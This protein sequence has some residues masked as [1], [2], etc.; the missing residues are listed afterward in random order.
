MSKYFKLLSRNIER[1]T[2][3]RRGTPKG[4]IVQIKG[5]VNAYLAKPSS[6]ESKKAVL[7]LP[8]IFGIWQN[9]KLMADA[10]AAQG[11]LCLV[12]DTFNGDP[13]PLEM[14]DGFDLMKWL[15]EG[16]D[17]NNPHTIDAVDPIVVSGIE[18]LK[19]IGVTQIAAAGYCLGAKVSRLV[20]SDN[21][22]HAD[23][24][25]STLFATTRVAFK[26]V[27]SPILLL[28]SRK[29]WLR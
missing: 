3:S 22:Q 15:S 16:S 1:Y 5:N 6:G 21:F 24:I 20:I 29:N 11:Y 12:V 9:S 19:G 27:S 13:V 4:T 23:T 7:Y 8:D 18:Y 25:S 17:G 2:D 10:F 26:S 28:W 14:P